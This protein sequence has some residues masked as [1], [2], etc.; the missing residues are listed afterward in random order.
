MKSIIACAAIMVLLL[1]SGLYAV[2]NAADVIL[3]EWYT[4]GDESVVEIYKCDDA[5]CG[6]IVWLKE[7]LTEKGEKKTDQNNT[8]ESLRDREII[9]LNI[10]EGFKYDGDNEWKGGTIYDPNKGKA[11][12]CKAELKGEKLKIRGFIGFSAFGRTTVWRRK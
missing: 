12:S 6:K 3:G 10:V 5:Y 7:P 8:D 1:A 2:G 11:Y 9:G 4:D